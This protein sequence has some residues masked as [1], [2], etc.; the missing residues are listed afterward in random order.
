MLG[1]A[2]VSSMKTSF[3]GSRSSWLSNQSSRR[4]RTS[5]RSCS[6]AWPVFFTRDPVPGEEAPQR[7]DAGA[8]AALGQHYPQLRQ[9]RIGL[10]LDSFQDEGC[11]VLDL[12]RPTITALRLG[13]RRA[14]NERQLPPPDRARRT[15]PETLGRSPAGHTTVDSS[16][17]AIPKITR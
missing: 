13:C 3:S 7:G 5:G 11:M 15:Y 17:N 9:R 2:Q 14:V 1:D 4:F 6:V 10:L 12:R 16:D 8:H